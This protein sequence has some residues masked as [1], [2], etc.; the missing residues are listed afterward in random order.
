MYTPRKFKQENIKQQVELI[1]NYPF[2]TLVVNTSDGVEVN[3]LPMLLEEH[4]GRLLLKG[5]IAKANPLWKRAE[6]GIEVKVI[7]N[8]PHCYISP[9]HYPSKSVDH[10]V[11]PTWNYAVVH[12]TGYVSFRHDSSFLYEVVEKL[13]DQH[14]QKS[15]KPWSISDAPEP[16]IEKMLTA[17]V[18]IEIAVSNIEGK[19]KLSQNQS[20]ENQDGVVRGLA[21]LED[22][23]SKAVSDMVK[24]V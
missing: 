13:T 12:V 21:K 11:V 17:I 8:G 23:M 22:A 10:R 9:N 14:E 24:K 19:W 15:A 2:A 3:H 6:E 16:F 4:K 1:E 20:A 18:G 7:F 5:H